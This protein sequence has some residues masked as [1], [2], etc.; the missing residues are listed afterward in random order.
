MKKSN[1]LLLL[2]ALTALPAISSCAA[3]ALE[4]EI[5]VV[6]RNEGEILDQG[7]VTQFKNVKSPVVGDAYIPTDYRFLG[8]TAYTLE[9]L[10]YGSVE[11]FRTQYIGGGRMVHYMDLYPFAKDSSTVVLDAL[12]LHKDD[13]PRE[14]H[15]AVLAWYD[16]AGTSGLTPEMMETYSSMTSDYLTSEGV[17]EEDVNSVVFRGYAGNVGPTTGQILYDGDVDIMLGWGSVSNI[18]TTGSIPEDS[19][20]ESVE[21]PILY[22]GAIKNRYIHRLTDNPGAI[23]LMDYL[24]SEASADFFNPTPAGE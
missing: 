8:W 1:A 7:T 21:F 2:A 12:I 24:K 15:Y 10:D 18:T 9:E 11:N 20:L 19:I 23:K 6:F 17:S 16:K 3:K 22:Q 4:R 13:I 5:N 14:Y